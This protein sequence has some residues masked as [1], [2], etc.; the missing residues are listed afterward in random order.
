[1]K[2]QLEKFLYNDQTSNRSYFTYCNFTN[3]VKSKLVN[4][5]QHRTETFV[6]FVHEICGHTATVAERLLGTNIKVYLT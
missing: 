3:R 5:V 4:R 1:M 6:E 2:R